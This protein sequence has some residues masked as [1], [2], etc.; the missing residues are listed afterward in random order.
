MNR[1]LR[2]I[3]QGKGIVQQGLVAEYRFDEGQGQVLTD[4]K[5]GYNGTLGSTAGADTNDP[6]WSSS[7]LAFATDDYVAGTTKAM[8]SNTDGLTVM[9]VANGNSSDS[10]FFV[11]QYKTD[12]NQRAWALG[13]KA[14]F[15][16]EVATSG[17]TPNAT[18]AYTEGNNLY[19]GVWRPN[20]KAKIILGDFSIVGE[21]STPVADMD[22]TSCALEFGRYN[23][24]VYMTGS[25]HYCLVYNRA[26]S[27]AEIRQNYKA[28]RN[29]MAQRGISI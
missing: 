14:F 21:S 26:L 18:M 27:D 11:G 28:I 16:Q 4:R 19:S 20:Q 17:G 25:M 23:T 7:G 5:G 1:I 24:S 9:V 13:N 22:D 8:W 6:T 15:V 2:Q 10:P 3:M 29:L 12:T